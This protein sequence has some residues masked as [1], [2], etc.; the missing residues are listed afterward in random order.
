MVARV[1]SR[2]KELAKGLSEEAPFA[3]D[4]TPGSVLTSARPAFCDG[5]EEAALLDRLALPPGQVA[6]GSQATRPRESVP[7]RLGPPL[8]LGSGI[9]CQP[10]KGPDSAL[11]GAVHVGE[12]GQRRLRGSGSAFLSFAQEN[13][14][15][16]DRICPGAYVSWPLKVAVR[17]DTSEGGDRTRHTPCAHSP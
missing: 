8:G 7:F 15:C 4:A 17:S 5:A 1:T 11:R 16:L 14:S 10:G 13:G 3:A 12:D 9:P 6:T 2:F